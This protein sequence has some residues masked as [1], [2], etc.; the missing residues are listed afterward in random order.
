MRL[1]DSKELVEI[2]GFPPPANKAERDA[3]FH[4]FEEMFDPEYV[5]DMQLL[6]GVA[7]PEYWQWLAEG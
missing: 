5:L 1:I 6:A 7:P 2:M 4:T 3:Y